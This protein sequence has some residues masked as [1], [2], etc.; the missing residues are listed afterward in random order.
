VARRASRVVYDGVGDGD[1][2]QSLA[3]LDDVLDF[4][5]VRL[6]PE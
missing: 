1:G 3:V 2:L 6:P 5:G 4:L